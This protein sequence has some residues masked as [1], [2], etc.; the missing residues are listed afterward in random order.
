MEA[1]IPKYKIGDLVGCQKADR[2]DFGMIVST[3]TQRHPQAVYYNIVWITND[4]RYSVG[5]PEY[6]ID[7]FMK[8]L[9]WAVSASTK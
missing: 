3:N 5:Y 4:N 6:Q 8:E 1:V 2:F 9:E 7:M